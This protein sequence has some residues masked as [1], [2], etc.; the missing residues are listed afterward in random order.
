MANSIQLKSYDEARP[1][2]R[3]NKW[4]KANGSLPGSYVVQH[5][6]NDVERMWLMVRGEAQEVAL[7]DWIVCT[8]AFYVS[9]DG[10]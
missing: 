2:G 9:E 1:G 3:A 5:D 4:L 10:E 6:A 8:S 7:G